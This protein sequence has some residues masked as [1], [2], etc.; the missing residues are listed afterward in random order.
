[1]ELLT[2]KLSCIAMTEL[3]K[4]IGT[5]MEVI[6]TVRIF[7]SSIIKHINIFQ[8]VMLHVQQKVA[9]C[10]FIRGLDLAIYTDLFTS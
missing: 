5:S 10:S 1:M 2:K 3:I 8:G 9:K 7:Y 4:S 6:Q